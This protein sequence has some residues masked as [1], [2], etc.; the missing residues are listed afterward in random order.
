MDRCTKRNNRCI[1]LLGSRSAFKMEESDWVGVDEEK[2]KDKIQNDDSASTP[3]GTMV[4]LLQ[5]AN[6]RLAEFELGENESAEVPI[7]DSTQSIQEIGFMKNGLMLI[8]L[9]C[10]TE[11]KNLVNLRLKGLEWSESDSMRSRGENFM[12]KQFV[13]QYESDVEHVLVVIEIGESLNEDVFNRIHELSEVANIFI[14][15]VMSNHETTNGTNIICRLGTIAPVRAPSSFASLCED[16]D[17]V[18]LDVKPNATAET[19]HICWKNYFLVVCC[20]VVA[21]LVQEC[22]V[23]SD[24]PLNRDIDARISALND[25]AVEMRRQIESL[26]TLSEKHDLQVREVQVMKNDMKL[27]VEFLTQ[28]LHKCGW[29]CNGIKDSMSDNHGWVFQDDV[30]DPRILFFTNQGKVILESSDSILENT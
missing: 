27:F 3:S 18:I 20:I 15:P 19:G 26:S 14:I 28:S 13:D 1:C 5:E 23:V 7:E 4:D 24:E 21:L 25:E 10:S 30:T 8:M 9:D 29:W 2:I 16:L 12:G 17:N 11:V 22:F 6:S